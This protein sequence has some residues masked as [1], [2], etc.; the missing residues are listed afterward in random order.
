M[1]EKN[2]VFSKILLGLEFALVL[3]IPFVIWW[4]TT[5]TNVINSNSLYKLL[6]IVGVCGC[7][8]LPVG[9][10]IGIV[11]IIVSKRMAQLRKITLVLSIINLS[12]GSIEILMGLVI[13]FVV[14]FGGASV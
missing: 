2:T 6:E 10:P 1:K 4:A 12:A 5:P 9:I 11:G 3:V 7:G 13:F 8:L 14:I